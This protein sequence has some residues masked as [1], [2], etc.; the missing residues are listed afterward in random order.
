MSTKLTAFLKFSELTVKLRLRIWGWAL[1][2]S[3]KY[4][5]TPLQTNLKKYMRT[6]PSPWFFVCYE[7]RVQTLRA[8]TGHFNSAR[9]IYLNLKVDS[10]QLSYNILRHLANGVYQSA[11]PLA[12]S[13]PPSAAPDLLASGDTYQ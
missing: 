8:Y 2:E 7:S 13:L 5:T 12:N 1:L 11:Q 9:P 10:I 6:V 3:S 4:T